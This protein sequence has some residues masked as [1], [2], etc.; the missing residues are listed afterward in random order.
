MKPLFTVLF[1]VFLFPLH[2]QEKTECRVLF[3]ALDGIYQGGCKD[4]LAHGKGTA[5]GT[6]SYT[7]AFRNGYPH[8]KGTYNWASGNTYKGEWNMGKREGNGVFTGRIDGKDTVMAGIWKDDK[9]MGQKPSPPNVSMKYNIVNA[10][11]TRTG[12]GNRISIS[13]YQNGLTNNVMALSIVTNT[14]SEVKSGNIINY[15]DIQFPFH[16]KINYQSYNGL[17]TQIF[18][19]ILEFEITQ[20][21]SWDLRVVN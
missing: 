9:F 12:D 8:G 17:R 21:G 11:F 18:D 16:C 3:P 1:T 14:G 4:G 13:F 2:A 20:A 19:C 7:G 15:Y 5:N 10:A 6:D